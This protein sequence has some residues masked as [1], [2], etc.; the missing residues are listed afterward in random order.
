MIS[1]CGVLC[2]QCPAFFGAT[3]G[4]AHQRRTAA[5]WEHIYGLRE[6]PEQITCG[7]CLAP[8]EEVF[9][10]CQECAAR[11]CCRSKGFS[12]CAECPLESCPDLE[13][14]QSGWDE[15]PRLIET[16]SHEDF[17]TYARPYCNHRQRL[18][19]IREGYH[20]PGEHLP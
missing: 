9:Y 8:D 13:K 4:I 7:G 11:R 15:V 3:Q 12:S 16:L 2:L 19:A 17:E 1:A 14:A 20:R 18:A 5:A 10:T 6:S